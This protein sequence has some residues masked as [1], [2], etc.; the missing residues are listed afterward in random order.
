MSNTQSAAVLGEVVTYAFGSAIA[1]TAVGIGIGML[2]LQVTDTTDPIE[3]TW[4][5]FSRLGLSALAYYT[6]SVSGGMYGISDPYCGGLFF[7]MGLL[8]A[9]P[10]LFKELEIMVDSYVQPLAEKISASS[11][12]VIY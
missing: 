6:V 4:K 5:L 2:P 3:T 1:G 10:S 8:K 12:E 7:G 11:S 9:Q